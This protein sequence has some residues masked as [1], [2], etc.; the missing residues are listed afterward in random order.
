MND[1]QIDI[2]KIMLATPRTEPHG[3]RPQFLPIADILNKISGAK[4]SW[5]YVRNVF[6]GGDVIRPKMR[7]AIETAARR[8]RR[9]E[10]EKAD[11][12]LRPLQVLCTQD[13]YNRMIN[14]STRGRAEK[15]LRK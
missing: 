2:K 11:C 12:R 1:I 6:V 9:R 7:N 3:Q 5:Q 8:I 13:E 10:A 15:M 4:W 14:Y